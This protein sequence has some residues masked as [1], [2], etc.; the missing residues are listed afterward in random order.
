[1]RQHKYPIELDFGKWTV[2]DRRDGV[3]PEGTDAAQL[4]SSTVTVA[5]PQAGAGSG[6]AAQPT[7]TDYLADAGSYSDD[8]LSDSDASWNEPS[9]AD[10]DRRGNITDRP[11]ATARVSPGGPG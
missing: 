3:M 2:V 10:D 8:P 1:Y 4:A 6:D 7:D 5:P 9:S 11:R